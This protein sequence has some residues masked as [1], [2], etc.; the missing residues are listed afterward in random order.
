M[1]TYDQ[2]I[3]QRDIQ[4]PEERR[5]TILNRNKQWAKPNWKT[6]TFKTDAEETAF[7][8]WVQANKIPFDPNDAHPDYDMRG[9]YQQLRTDPEA[10]KTMINPNDGKPHFTDEHKT[11]YHAT[12]SNESKYAT[13]HAPAWNEHDQL[14]TPKGQVI[15]SEVGGI[16]G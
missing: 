16:G 8:N 13:K 11:P 3:Q 12:F 1:A 5:Q 9:Y 2:K 10:A 15:Y 6:T 14:V 4:T 7:Q